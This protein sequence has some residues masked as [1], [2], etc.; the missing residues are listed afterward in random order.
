[1]GDKDDPY[2][3]EAV[4]RAMRL[5]TLLVEREQLSVTEAAAELGVAP[6]TAHRL[7]S[8]M[9]YRD[10][11]RQGPGRVYLPGPQLVQLH[12][13]EVNIPAVVGR[14]RSTVQGLFE[15][16]GETV[17]LMVRIGADV[18]FVDGVEADRALRIGL[19]IGT[20]IPAYCTSGGKAMLAEL[21]DETL[22]D[23]H[24]GGLRPW[25]SRRIETMTQLR[26]EL[27]R[28][29]MRGLGVNRDESEPGVTALG[30][31][32]RPASGD[33]VVALTVAVPTTRFQR[34]DQE[35]LISHLRD[36]ASR[37]QA[38]LYGSRGLR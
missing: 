16:V 10:Y 36:A 31:A 5:L 33:P 2:R 30:V 17:H 1:M 27:H 6:S 21:S 25:P 32:L 34:I 13:D 3:I 24:S 11:V 38:E 9:A 23:L 19:R 29:R 7:L 22:E 26:A 12:R 8:T 20:R 4:D 18:Q 37:G 14:L 35:Q 15:A 28:I